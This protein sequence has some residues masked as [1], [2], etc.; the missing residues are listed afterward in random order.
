[1]GTAFSVYIVLLLLMSHFDLICNVTV[2][3]GPSL[4]ISPTNLADIHPV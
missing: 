4:A 3:A 2:A 1:M